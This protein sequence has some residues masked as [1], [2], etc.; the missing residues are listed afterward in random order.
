MKVIVDS[1]IVFSALLKSPNRFCDTICLSGDEFYTPKF[2]FVE[3]FKYKERIVRQS[4][5]TE[6]SA[7]PGG[8]A[9]PEKRRFC[10]GLRTWW[11]QYGMKIGEIKHYPL[12]NLQKWLITDVTMF[13]LVANNMLRTRLFISVKYVVMRGAIRRILSH[14]IK[15]VGYLF[16][17][18]NVGD[19]IPSEK[20]GL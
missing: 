3:I 15:V 7:T 18:Q 6:E 17:A 13:A 5:M 16:T 1:N 8:F 4:K 19:L 10:V 14:Q 20:L 2:M 11:G 12:L 9:F